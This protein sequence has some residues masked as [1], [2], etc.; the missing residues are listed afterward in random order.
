MSGDYFMFDIMSRLVFGLSFHML[1][2]AE[3]HWIIDAVIGQTRRISFLTQL[4][5]IED[6]GIHRILFPEARKKA[7][8]FSA[9]SREIMEA[10]K[11]MEDPNNIDISSKLL[12]ARD[13]ETGESLSP[14]Q[15]WAESNLLII[16]G[17]WTLPMTWF[18]HLDPRLILLQVPT[19]PLLE[20]QPPT[21]T[22]HGTDLHTTKWLRR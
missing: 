18:T 2:K 6:L 15:L 5:E 4:P 12:A 20:W 17:K 11:R 14:S 3:N 10:R 22:F 1:E 7:F 19:L 8:R 13:A 21:S 9:K 16:A